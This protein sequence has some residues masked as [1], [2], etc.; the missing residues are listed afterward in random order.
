MNPG[1]VNQSDLRKS[2]QFSFSSVL[3][4][5]TFVPVLGW[6]SQSR[7]AVLLELPILVKSLAMLHAK[8]VNLV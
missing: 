1:N 7:E 4:V 6:L 5:D 8:Q 2:I 3:S